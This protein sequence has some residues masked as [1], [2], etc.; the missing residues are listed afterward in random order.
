MI[1]SSFLENSLSVDISISNEEILEY[2]TSSKGLF[3]RK[4]EEVFVHH[5][6]LNELEQA[7]SIKRELIKKD[8]KEEQK[9]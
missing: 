3:T 5:F 4:E 9:K 7:R 6:F 8:N 2:Y 1:I